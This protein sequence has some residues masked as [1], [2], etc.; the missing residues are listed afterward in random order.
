MVIGKLL[1]KVKKALDDAPDER[2]V[3]ESVA[4]DWNNAYKGSGDPEEVTRSVGSSTGPVVVFENLDVRLEVKKGTTILDAA[5]AADI[6]LDHYCGGMASCGSCRIQ[7]LP[8][9]VVS[10][11]DMM[12]EATLDVVLEH[13]DDRLGCQ[14]KVL[15]EVRV[16]VPDQ[17]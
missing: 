13:D 3:T 14:T 11:M 8:G 2:P 1:R 16:L 5:I 10:E 4:D 15:G 7:I 9:S 6:D 12:E 17:D